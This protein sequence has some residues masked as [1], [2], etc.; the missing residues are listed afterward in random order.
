VSSRWL[1][2]SAPRPYVILWIAVISHLPLQVIIETAKPTAPQRRPISADSAIMNPESEVIALKATV[3]GTAGDNL[4]VFNLAAKQKLKSVQFGQSVVFWKWITPSRLGLVTATAVYHWDVEGTADPV[5]VFDRSSNLENT[6]IIS[7][8]VDPTGKWCV[9]VGI[10]P[11]APERPQLVKGFM[12]LYSVEQS[13]SQALEAHAAAFAMLKLAGKPSPV[14]VIAF[15]QKTLANGQVASKVHVIELGQPGQTSLKKSAELF[16][17]P[18]FADDFPVAMQVGAKYGLVY[19][20]TKLG[21]LF[22]YDIE[23]AT[24][25][26][27]TRISADPVFI[28]AGSADSGFIA[29]NR[30]GQV[31]AGTVNE[32]AIV[33]FV[34]GQLQNLD[35]AMALATRANLPGAEQLVVQKF[36]R[37]FAAGQYKEAAELAADSPQGA[38]RTKETVEGFK[39]VPSQ[40]GQTSPLL[41][42]FGTI[43]T[44]SRLNE[45]E[46]VE[47]GRLVMSQNKKHLLDN[48][49][50]EGKLTPSEELGD[51]YKNAAD[52]DTA[53]AIYQTC[54]ASGKVVE[55]LAAKGDFDQLATYTRSSGASPDYT[56]LLQRLMMDNPDA[57][58]NLAKMVAR[59]PGPPLDLNSL[60]DLFLQRNMVRE[61]TAFLLDV[62]QDD[63]PKNAA[64]QTKLLEINLVTNPQVADAILANGT[65]THYDRPRVA[66]L[67]EKAGLYIR[68]LQHYSDLV[69]IK[70]VVV[71]TH[72]I[73]PAALIEFFGT[74]S[75]EWALECLRVLLESN[76]TQNLQIV[77][78]VAKEYTEQLTAIRIIELLESHE[79][80]HGLYFYL[81]SYIAFSEDPEVHYKYIE[82]AAKTGPVA[83]YRLESGHRGCAY[84]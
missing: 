76:M 54:G 74:L 31:L 51:L 39:R 59:Q 83:S 47:L 34:S 40:P 64:L 30:R 82:A 6:Q 12:Q 27:R 46:S 63:D 79:S 65:L 11:G 49:Y 7:Y 43:L 80:Y 75:A 4:Q 68:A 37:L 15:A 32:A 14:P 38:L 33:P 9:L 18:E 16:F 71:N 62:L 52:W 5:K 84:S 22:V 17:P 77:V 35:L 29:V 21:L 2:R 55:A 78:N 3:A 61:A 8:K 10:A 60:A 26:Y 58:V 36:Q 20:I 73:E 72:A 41:V 57:A 25:V 66:Q 48:W 1:E 50:K 56:F 67:C 81:G 69:D 42:Y 24:A 70:R 53:L 13:R 19:V 45:F 28:A 44:K 23:S